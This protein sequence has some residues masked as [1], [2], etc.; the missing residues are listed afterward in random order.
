MNYHTLRHFISRRLQGLAIL[1]L[2]VL[3]LSQIV[4]HWFAELFSHFLPHYTLIWLL[5]AM[6]IVHASRWIWLGLSFVS[7]VFLIWQ[8]THTQPEN[9]RMLLWYNVNLNNP[10]AADESTFILAQQA[11]IIALAEIDLHDK[12][13]QT[14]RTTYPYGCQHQED[15]PFAL[16][17][18]SKTPLQHC[19]VAFAGQPEMNFAYIQAQWHDTSLFALHPPP[20]INA[21]M[22]AARQAYLQQ[23]AEK[24][25]QQQRVVAIGD[26][27]SSP[28]SPIF[29][30]FTQ[31]ADLHSHLPFYTPTWRPF[32]LNIDHVLSRNTPLR[33]QVL[34]F[35]HSDHRAIT[36]QLQP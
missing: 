29:R 20:P 3:I 9:A 11:D 16:V 10:A 23:T 22:A 35:Q 2:S 17:L 19:T 12:G 14:L 6:C 18:W 34:P 28:F 13:W 25:A 4:P 36:I 8:P 5:A 15:S 24:M 21:E 26:L 1:S 31:Q 33:A 32:A 27:N 30:A 7:F